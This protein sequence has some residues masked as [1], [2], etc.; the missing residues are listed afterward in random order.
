MKKTEMD[1]FMKKYQPIVKKTGEQ[2]AKVAKT[3]EEDISKLYR[4]AQTHIEIQMK[5][6]QKEKLYHEIGKYVAEQLKKE[7]FDI[8]ILQKYKARLEKIDSEGA[9]M[10][11]KIS[12]IAKAGKKK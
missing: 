2:L 7:D 1:S 11:K 8:S 4:I 3:A 6:L 9:K 12:R 5:N 10:R